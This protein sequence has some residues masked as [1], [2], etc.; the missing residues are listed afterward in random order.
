LDAGETGRGHRRITE[1]QNRGP[2]ESR[3]PCDPWRHLRPG[4]PHRPGATVLEGT[5]VTGEKPLRLALRLREYIHRPGR[6][7]S[8]FQMDGD[9]M[10]R[11]RPHDSRAEDRPA[12]R[13][14]A[15]R[16]PVR[17]SVSPRRFRA[18]TIA[19]VAVKTP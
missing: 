13:L 17:R 6:D 19:R 1:G 7:G 10:R 5:E 18:L 15:S 2:G 12:I 16:S 8:G 3:I 9:G 14:R 11:T 4:G